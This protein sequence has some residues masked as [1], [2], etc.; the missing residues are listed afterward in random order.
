MTY[1]ML[2]SKLKVLTFCIIFSILYL[3]P[4]LLQDNIYGDDLTFHLNRLLSL[5][6]VHQS[7]VDFIAFLSTGQNVNSFYPFVTYYPLNLLWRLTDNLYFSYYFY[8]FCF[9]ALTLWIAYYSYLLVVNG[10]EKG[11][12]L[13]SVLYTFASYRSW[14]IVGRM[15]VGEYIAWTFVPLVLAGIYL[16]CAG[17]FKKWRVLAVGMTFITY[18]HVLSTF[19]LTL[20]LGLVAVVGVVVVRNRLLFISSLLKSGA[21]TVLLSSIVI[22]P[23]VEQ[24]LFQSLSTPTIRIL[25]STT[26]TVKDMLLTS[27]GNRGT[28]PSLGL[29]LIIAVLILFTLMFQQMN[30][31][32][33]LLYLLSLMVLVMISGFFDWSWLQNTPVKLIQFVWRLYLFPT[34]LVSFL[35]SKYLNRWIQNKQI[36]AM[37][38]MAIVIVSGSYIGNIM[39]GR[40]EMSKAAPHLVVTKEQSDIWQKMTKNSNA[41]YLPKIAIERQS[42]VYGKKTYLNGQEITVDYQIQPRNVE[43]TVSLPESGKLELPF[44]QYKGQQI[45]VDGVVQSTDF[46]SGIASIEVTK[47]RH[48]IFLYYRHTL[49]TK[50]SFV[51]SLFSWMVFLLYIIL[52][53]PLDILRI[54]RFDLTAKP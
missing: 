30:R 34:I 19:I 47:G 41:D 40:L 23:M 33:V 1:R 44:Y 17:E 29:T 22:F 36:R 46:K 4:F 43:A 27:I 6:T 21:V 49:L 10:K 2:Q 20:F 52:N 50:L 26:Q 14:N 51:L 37:I 11:A 15:A 53:K 39:S 35:I 48:R 45:E 25:Q 31:W 9:T 38:M 54:S 8:L 42:D 5:R 24:M 18:S 28:V 32:D 16:I 3:I 7:P 13:F 12:Y